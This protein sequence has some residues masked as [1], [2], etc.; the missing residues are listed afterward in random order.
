M[1]VVVNKSTRVSTADVKLAT[2]ACASQLRYH[3]APAWSLTPV[4]VVWYMHEEHVPPGA[5]KILIF[6]DPDQAGVLGWHSEG[7][8]GLPFGRVFAA[9]TLDNHVSVSSVLSHEVLEAFVDPRVNAWA[10]SPIGELWALEVGDPVESFGYLVKVDNKDVEVSD[11]ALP[12]FFD[13]AARPGKAVDF[14][15]KLTS[16]FSLGKGGY[17]V[18]QKAGSINE[19]FGENYPAWKMSLKSGG[20]RTAR[21]MDAATV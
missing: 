14:M 7:P 2:R 3:A 4:P 10:M 11:F 16:P 12:A 1:I 15:G 6:D 5:W 18:I 21:R 17:G 19:R 9:P 13:G 8:D 20:S